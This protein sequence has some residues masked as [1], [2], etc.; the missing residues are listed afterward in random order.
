[1]L[2]RFAE[3]RCAHCR[4]SAMFTR[5][6]RPVGAKNRASG[7]R[8]DSSRCSEGRANAAHRCQ[9]RM[10]WGLG[11]IL[12]LAPMTMEVGAATE[13]E[14]ARAVRGLYMAD[15]RAVGHLGIPGN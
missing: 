14:I 12:Y 10:S 4:T 3:L 11:M 5:L 8:I 9:C 13:R 6:A 7:V 1:M 2:E 15:C